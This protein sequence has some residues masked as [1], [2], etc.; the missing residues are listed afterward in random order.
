MAEHARRQSTWFKRLFY[1]FA[2]WRY[3]YAVR[4]FGAK[5]FYFGPSKRTREDMAR[6]VAGTGP[7]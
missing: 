6:A 1:R 3:Y 2:A 5:A 4:L 7:N